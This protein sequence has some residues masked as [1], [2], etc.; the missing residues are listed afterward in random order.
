MEEADTK[1]RSAGCGEGGADLGGADRHDSLD[2]EEAQRGREEEAGSAGFDHSA[3]DQASR[4]R[5]ATRTW[6]TQAHPAGGEGRG[7]TRG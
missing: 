2:E 5:T 1:A 4:G 6:R 3:R 7:P